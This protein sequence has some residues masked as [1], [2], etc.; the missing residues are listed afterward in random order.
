M[1]KILFIAAV[2]SVMTGCGGRQK[3]FMRGEVIDG[4]YRNDFFGF[5]MDIPEGMYVMSRTAMDSLSTKAGSGMDDRAAGRSDLLLFISAREPF[6]ADSLF[7]YNITITS[8]S[9]SG[10][11]EIKTTEQYISHVVNALHGVADDMPVGRTLLGNREFMKVS[12]PSETISQDIYTCLHD[13]YALVVVGSYDGAQQREAVERIL[14]T[15][16]F[17]EK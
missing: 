13:G 11:P 2:I 6:A 16:V 12:I 15:I 8:E 5:T 10:I 1:R 4:L 7:N 9:L 3:E 17:E 14:T